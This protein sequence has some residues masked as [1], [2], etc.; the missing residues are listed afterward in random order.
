[1][2]F[3]LD[4][5]WRRL[6]AERAV[7]PGN[8]AIDVGTGTG[9][10]AVELHRAG[11]TR[12]LGADFSP[13]ML[14]AAARRHDASS[15][16]WLQAD[17][18]GLPFPDGVFDCLTNAFVLRNL[19]DLRAGLAEMARVV[20]PGGR[21][22]CLDLTQPPAGATGRAYRLYFER[23]VPALAGLIS[24]DREAYR[25]L[26]ASLV[27]FPDARALSRLLRETGLGDVHVKKLAAGA[28]ALHVAVKPQR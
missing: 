6:A 17:V 25:Y 5:H 27:G 26:P 21:L 10:L 24:G 7:S 22:V 16:E 3:G 20:R 28:V 19:A 11:G 23:I 2:S 12:V 8:L 18:L 15:I 14:A 13:H 4:R 9:D 1:M